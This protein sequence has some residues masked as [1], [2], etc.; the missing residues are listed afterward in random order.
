[1]WSNHQKQH[2]PH[3]AEQPD[4]DC[5]EVAWEVEKVS[6]IIIIVAIILTRC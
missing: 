6:N 2:L 3:Q 1:M 5:D 4:I